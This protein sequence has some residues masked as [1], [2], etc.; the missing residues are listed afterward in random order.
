[1][2]HLGLAL[3]S[4]KPL[5]AATV[6]IS[7]TI[8]ASGVGL[9]G[10]TVDAGALGSATTNGSGQYMISAV[11]LGSAY[12]LTPS[13][14]TYTFSPTSL[15]GTANGNISNADFTATVAAFSP[16]DLASLAGW[17]DASDSCYNGGSVA[18]NGQTV[19]Q[20]RDKS[21]HAYHLTPNSTPT[22]VSSGV[23][24]LGVVSF[25][26][27]DDTLSIAPTFNYDK[28][29]LFVVIKHLGSD[30]DIIG[31]DNLGNGDILLQ[32]D[33]SRKAKAHIWT[34]GGANAAIHGTTINDNDVV[35]LEQ[36]VDATSINVAVN[37]SGTV[38]T[39]LAGSKGDTARNLVLASRYASA[40]GNRFGKYICEVILTTVSDITIQNRTDCIEYLKSK[41]GIA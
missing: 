28:H 36:W 38:T 32:V 19:T 15:T 16:L 2:I 13:K 11:P 4:Q 14:A 17:W 18:T 24:S 10:V 29:H 34:S 30:K 39:S 20:L 40:G 31:S 5:G 7:G 22:F 33:A 3:K 9:S 6:S 27:V 37:G 1:M 8:T 21:G 23:N 41:W 25:D 26:G 12:T 35:I